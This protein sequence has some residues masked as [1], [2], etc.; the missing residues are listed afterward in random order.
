MLLRKIL[1]KLCRFIDYFILVRM[2]HNNVIKIDE[3]IPEVFLCMLIEIKMRN[4]SFGKNLS[5]SW[6]FVPYC[7]FKKCEE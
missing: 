3:N 7:S 6:N 4:D 1:V 5:P 2:L